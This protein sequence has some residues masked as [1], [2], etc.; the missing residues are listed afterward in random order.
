MSGAR[1]SEL[2]AKPPAGQAEA[3]KRELKQLQLFRG[4]A[5]LVVV[6]WEDLG[7]NLQLV[8][9]VGEEDVALGEQTDG[10]RVGLAGL[11]MSPADYGRSSLVARLRSEPRDDALLVKRHDIVWNGRSSRSS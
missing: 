3:I 1:L 2:L 10:A 9:R 5:T 6:T 7:A 11:Q 8:A 4:P